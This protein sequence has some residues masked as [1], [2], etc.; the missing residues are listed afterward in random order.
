MDKFQKGQLASRFQ[1][2]SDESPEGIK[3]SPEFE[4]PVSTD[5]K[6]FFDMVLTFIKSIYQNDWT[7]FEHKKSI[8][9]PPTPEGEYSFSIEERTRIEKH[10]T[11]MDEVKNDPHHPDRQKT[12]N[13]LRRQYTEGLPEPGNS[14]QPEHS[15]PVRTFRLAG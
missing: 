4:T 3:L 15:G 12:E 10:L 14:P 11:R 9:F 6:N 5:I 13:D 7:E 1:A 2:H 8:Y